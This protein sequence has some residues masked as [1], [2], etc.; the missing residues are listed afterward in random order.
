MFCDW[1]VGAFNWLKA[2]L[3]NAA[4]SMV[5]WSQT[6]QPKNPNNVNENQL[7]LCTKTVSTLNI[8]TRSEEQNDLLHWSGTF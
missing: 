8:T 1:F 5:L 6:R 3:P 2:L 7:Y 4:K